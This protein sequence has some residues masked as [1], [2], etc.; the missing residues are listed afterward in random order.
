MTQP[1]LPLF[2]GH[3][4]DAP[5]IWRDGE[6]LSRRRFWAQAQALA[7]ELPEAGAAINLCEDRYHFLLGF[8]AL[9]LRGQIN[10]LPPDRAKHTLQGLVE[11][12]PH[13]YCLVDQ[14]QPELPGLRQWVMQIPSEALPQGGPI[15]LAAT[16]PVATVF[17][18]GS[19]G[20]STPQHK[21]WGELYHGAQRNR[22]ALGLAQGASLLATVPAQHMYGLET[23][24]LLP[25]V[26]ELVVASAR[27]FFPAD[28]QRALQALPTPRYLISTPLHLRS[29][30]QS[31][32]RWPSMAGLVS[33]TA[34]LDAALAEALEARFDC[35]LHEIYGSSETGAI[36]TR[37]RAAEDVWRLHPGLRLERVEDGWSVAGGHLSAPR[38]LSD[39]LELSG[40]GEFQLLGRHEDLIKIAGKRASLSDLNHQLQA[41]A[42]VEDGVFVAPEQAGDGG[43][44]SALVVAPTLDRAAIL[45]ALGERI[46]AAFLP[47]PLYR[48]ASL[49]RNATGKLPRK[50]LSAFIRSLKE[51]VRGQ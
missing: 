22:Q 16:Q 17:T 44:L 32:L 26:A 19:T 1:E 43:R 24:V 2:C 25:L 36:A 38:L 46:D 40:E 50:V 5:F 12:Y 29:C 14:A 41:I 49:P 7:A 20:H 15:R 42:G 30:L 28:V 6:V 45:A 34:S 51:S 3:D 8:V 39:R 4:S 10:L 35:P 37:R 27:P 48:V 23:S 47:R 31:E 11:Q 18:S 9:L 21:C 13:S 33:A